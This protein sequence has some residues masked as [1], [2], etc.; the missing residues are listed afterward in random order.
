MALIRADRVKETSTT[1]S[2]GAFALAG[3]ASGYRSF[4]SVCSVGD[5]VYYSIS[6]Q[7]ANEWEVGLGTYSATNTLTRT[8]VHASSNANTA[9]N[10]SAGTKDVF[11]TL[12]KTQLETYATLSGSETLTN[13]TINASNNTVTN[14][15]LTT[16]VTGTLPIA[17][18]GTASTT[19]AAAFNALNPM[20]TLGD[21]IYEASAGSAARLAGNT[22]STKQFLSQ[23]GTGTASAAPSW[24]AV[25]KTDVG[26]G[27]VENTALSTWA[28]SANITTVGTVATGTWNATTIGIAKG[29][30]GQTTASAAFNALMPL[31]TLGDILY[32]SGANTSARLAGNTTT[33]KR[34]LSQ[35]GNGT[36]SAAPSWS[37]VTSS[38]VGLGSV[39][40]TALS[41][42]AGSTNITTLG[43]VATGTWNATTISIA[44][45]GTGQTTANAGLNALLPTQTGNSSKFL[46]TDGSNTSWATVSSSPGGSNR[47]VQYNDNGN[48]S[49]ANWWRI[50]SLTGIPFGAPDFGNDLA[51]G[52]LSYNTRRIGFTSSN[53]NIAIGGYAMNGV[54]SG[55]SNVTGCTAV[56]DYAMSGVIYSG[57]SD[58]YNCTAIGAGTWPGWPAN[59][60]NCTVLGYQAAPTYPGISTPYALI[61]D[62]I[63]LGNGSITKLRCAVTSITSLS[64]ARDK[65]DIQPIPSVLEFVS[66]L[67]PVRFEWAM[68][69][70]G[71]VGLKDYGFIAQ[72]L[73]QA[74][75]NHGMEWAELVYDINP[76]RLEAS[77]GKLI[78]ILVKAIQE[79]YSEV[80][81]LKA[82]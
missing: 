17:N 82:R 8:T 81:L 31:T 34:F 32:A 13:K 41:T 68:R 65:T 64:D 19:A 53:G 12:T 49:G 15:S 80:K 6:H 55:A 62:E 26:L 56:G 46:T 70:G 1:T 27:S 73:K 74:E 2:T 51:I 4:A 23:T 18:G 7:S 58:L 5:T 66:A 43:T 42:W 16:G 77:P 36:I 37:T 72:E 33:T 47:Q 67:N 69:D 50:D 21:I 60:D 52:V 9:V 25:S 20:T 22:T 59:A 11:L 10:F 61:S 63:T 76:D 24:S 44:K 29:G 79:L 54:A 45:G 35:T 78:P 75:Q 39:E 71:K 14:V 3:A 30:T 48:F 38:D 28:G 57:S 40:N